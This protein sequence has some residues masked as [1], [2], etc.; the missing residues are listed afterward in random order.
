MSELEALA[1]RMLAPHRQLQPANAYYSAAMLRYAGVDVHAAGDADL[2]ESV[3]RHGIDCP[4][5][6]TRCH[7]DLLMGFV[8][9]P[10]LRVGAP[11][12]HLRLPVSQARSRG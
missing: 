9:G 5:R 12:L 11:V 8:V 7:L 2:Y 6:S 3:L 10:R 4:R 1:G